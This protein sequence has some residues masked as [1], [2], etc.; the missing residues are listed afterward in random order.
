MDCRFYVCSIHLLLTH[1]NTKMMIKC[2]IAHLIHIYR[3]HGRSHALSGAG[4]MK[5]MQ[6]TGSCPCKSG[7][8]TYSDGSTVRK[9]RKSTERQKKPLGRLSR[10]LVRMAHG[11]LLSCP[12]SLHHDF[13]DRVGESLQWRLSSSHTTVR[14]VRYTA[15]HKFSATFKYWESMDG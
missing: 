9:R 2:V 13:A 11:V 8:R 1:V 10:G 7:S 4:S 5:N 3:L 14:T 15:V 12:I 6:K